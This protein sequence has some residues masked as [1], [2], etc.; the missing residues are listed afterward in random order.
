MNT[1]VNILSKENTNNYNFLKL[2]E[3]LAELNTEV[4][5]VLSRGKVSLESISNISK[6]VA[7]VE[8]RI[9]VIKNIL[10]LEKQVDKAIESKTKK[11]ML[12]YHANKLGKSIKP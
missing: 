9:A 8:I 2:S 4:L 11:L 3:E 7:D 6:E 10:N 1:L 5:Q 12:K